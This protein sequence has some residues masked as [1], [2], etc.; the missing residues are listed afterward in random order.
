MNKKLRILPAWLTVILIGLLLVPGFAS[1]HAYIVKS[2]PG[3]NEMLAQAPAKVVIDFNEPLQKAFHSI[4]VTDSSGKKVNLS[5]SRIPEGESSA[6]EADLQPDLPQGVYAVQWKAVSADGHP[7]EGTFSF[8]IGEGGGSTGNAAHSVVT[9]PD[10]PGTDQ[11]IIRWLIYTSLAFLAGIYF[12]Q[13]Y[14]LP[15]GAGSRLEWSGRS[16]RLIWI[17]IAVLAA[18]FLLSLPLQTGIDAGVGWRGVWSDPSLLLKMLRITSFGEVWLVQ[19]LLLVVVIALAAAAPRIKDQ[20]Q[21]YIT[22]TVTF[23][24]LMSMLLAKSFTGHPAASESKALA[25]TMDFLHLG[26]ASLWLGCLLAFAVLLPKEASLPADT[27]NRKKGYFAV[28]R[29]FSLWGTGFV[30]LI[31]IS[32]IYASLQYVPTWYSL[33]HTSYG[34][35]LLAKCALL[36][37]MLLCAAWNML[38]G[39]REQRSLGAGV[40]LELTAGVLALMLAA[41]LTNMP[42]AM[43][44]PG[45]VHMQ[46]K[47]ENQN[48][49]TLDITPNTTGVNEFEVKVQDSK[50]QPVK[51]IQQIKLTL[52]CLDMDMGK[53][54]IVMPGGKA[55]GYKA[56][57]LISMAGKWNVHVHVLTDKLETWDTDMV[58]HVGNH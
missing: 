14:L 30:V 34:K 12:F 37:I 40:W 44:S 55:E 18:S 3:E 6:L 43:S 56:E 9:A 7:V 23:L 38:R 46:Q 15:V 22:R 33:F 45:P 35:V 4:I 11:V 58:I 26:A 28:I 57:D 48:L 51:G 20:D 24:L 41:A 47:L 25:I 17:N 32:G 50:G 52:T 10:W 2:M 13:L 1:A 5:E 42:T 31:L 8:Q 53:Y 39:R 36:L 21:A 19:L 29:R 54:E 49:V 27:E 16:T